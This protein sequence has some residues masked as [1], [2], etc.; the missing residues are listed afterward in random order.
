MYPR[1]PNLVNGSSKSDQLS[2]RQLV[3]IRLLSTNLPHDPEVWLC[4]RQI[5]HAR[6]MDGFPAPAGRFR[7]DDSGL[8]YIFVRHLDDACRRHGVR[9]SW[10]SDHWVGVIELRKTRSRVV[11]YTFDLNTAGASELAVDKVCC[12]EALDASG[13]AAVPHHFLGTSSP[14]PWAS[15]IPD[16]LGLPVVAKPVRGS[17]GADVLLCRDSDE[18][19][20]N[21]DKLASKYTAISLSPYWDAD[22]EYRVVILDGAPLLTFRKSR[23]LPKGSGEIREWRANLNLGAHAEVVGASNPVY[24]ELTDLAVRANC[25][26][27]L[28]FAAVDMLSAGGKLA[29]LEVNDAF[30]LIHFAHQDKGHDLLTA[31][32]Y[33]T[34][35]AA[36]VAVG[37]P[38]RRTPST[39]PSL[40]L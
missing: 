6:T 32:V 5:R 14:G 15:L 21:L 27:G 28:R 37:D 13:V 22:C 39:R 9:I 7:S 1:E 23:R 40:P 12:F 35:V 4:R 16:H 30:S 34:V 26:L 29:V 17:G 8:R 3:N 25:A 20:R 10:S 33:E 36:A 38:A 2:S 19:D 18:L 24:T 11:G 31:E